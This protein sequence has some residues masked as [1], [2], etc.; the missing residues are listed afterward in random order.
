MLCGYMD[1]YEKILEA[2]RSFG[3]QGCGKDYGDQRIQKSSRV[4]RAES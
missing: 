4:A 2:R 3:K 1:P